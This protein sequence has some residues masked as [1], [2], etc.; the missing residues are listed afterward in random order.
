MLPKPQIDAGPITLGDIVAAQRRQLEALGVD[1]WGVPRRKSHFGFVNEKS[2]KPAAAAAKPSA[3]APWP[4]T[5]S[6]RGTVIAPTA[7]G[8]SAGTPAG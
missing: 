8:A 2:A 1:V 6:V 4:W 3:M 5:T 7:A